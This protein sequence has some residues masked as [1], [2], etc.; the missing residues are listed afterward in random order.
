MRFPSAHKAAQSGSDV[1]DE[2]ANLGDNSDSGKSHKF[3]LHSLRERLRAAY[4]PSGELTVHEGREG[5][6]AC[7][8]VPSSSESS[9]LDQ[10]P[11]GDR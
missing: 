7:F 5:F 1:P 3:G 6:E 11:G 9:A 10:G 2:T 8:V 4:G